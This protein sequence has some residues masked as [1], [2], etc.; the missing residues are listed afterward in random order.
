MPLAHRKPPLNLRQMVEL[1][2]IVSAHS[3]NL[4]E[5]P[6]SLSRDA[7]QRYADWSQIRVRN[8]LSAIDELPREIMAIP[9]GLRA[10]IWEQAEITFV[11]VLAGGLVA[12]VWGAVLTACE[13]SRRTVAAEKVARSVMAGQSQAQ[14]GVLRMLV[15]GRHLE[16]ERIAALD[17]LR[18]N[19]ERW[20]DLLL[21]HLVRRYALPDFAH[22]LERALDFGEEQLR[23]SWGPRRNSIWDLYFICLQS[24]F[25]GRRL[26]GGIQGIWR[27]ELLDS[28]LGCFRPEMFA[29]DGP[30]MSVR[31]TR[32]LNSGGLREGPPGL[33]KR[34]CAR[35]AGRCGRV[36]DPERLL[37]REPEGGGVDEWG[38]TEAEE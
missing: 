4:I 37:D 18:R 29:G 1:T 28:I 30:L 27:E 25:P 38:T 23:E 32:L 5:A 31:L 17:R 22:D 11:D 12:R 19:I 34:A 35:L 15:D 13:H 8:W 16:R 6:G 21:G 26:P 3:P 9:V 36:V 20:T 14:L 10:L 2:G 24:G 7:L 33:G